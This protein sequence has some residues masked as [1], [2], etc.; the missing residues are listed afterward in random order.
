MKTSVKS[1]VA[2]VANATPSKRTRTLIRVGMAFSLGK[3]ALLISSE[4]L[5]HS[6]LNAPQ[7]VCLAKSNFYPFEILTEHPVSIFL[8]C[9]DMTRNPY[10]ISQ[11]IDLVRL[12]ENES[13]L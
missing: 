11:L 13:T 5:Q 6:H 10:S 7:L 1:A 3:V 8:N 2:G 4:R 12:P 9:R